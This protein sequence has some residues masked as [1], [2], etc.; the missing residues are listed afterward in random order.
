[1]GIVFGT[2]IWA[3]SGYFG[4]TIIFKTLPFFY[5]SLK[6][7]GG[8]YL[9]YLGVKYMF[10]NKRHS[11]EKKYIKHSSARD[12]FLN[13]AFTNLLNPKTAAFITSLF[14]AA[15]PPN[16]SYQT[17]LLSIA[18]ICSISALWYSLVAIIFSR[19]KV[20]KSY[21]NYKKY[22]E[23]IAGGIFVFFGFTHTS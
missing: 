7:A 8:L 22:I 23:K 1:M 14:A 11:V 18:L 15:I 19:E 12:H 2:F 9:I 17:G 13:G 20:R 16:H 5:Y 10:S 21:V 4:L 6:I 3:A